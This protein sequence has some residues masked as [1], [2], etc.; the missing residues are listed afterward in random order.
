MS[1]P[2]KIY[3]SSF[4]LKKR[5]L[6][7]CTGFLSGAII[8][9]FMALSLQAQ[10][11]PTK[12]PNV[13]LI[14]S[15]D[16]N[17]YMSCYGHPEVKTPNM[18]RLAKHAIQF[19]HAYCQYPLCNPSRTSFMS[20]LRPA[21]TK[22]IINDAPPRTYLKDIVFI[23]E[24]FHQFGYFTARVGKIAHQTYSDAIHWD[25][26]EFSPESKFAQESRTLQKAMPKPLYDKFPM[27]AADD[28]DKDEQDGKTA[29]RIV[30]LLEENKD[31]QFFIAA[32][33]D[34]PHFPLVAP[35]K[36]FDLYPIDKIK[37]PYAPPDDI[38]DV[39]PIA[40]VNYLKM[41]EA[42]TRGYIQG[43][44]ACASFCDA[45][46]GILL[47]AMDRL[48]L[49][50]NT[51]VVFFG[52]H[53][54]CIGEHG[55][56]WS[57]DMLF[58]EATRVPYFVAAPGKKPAVCERLIEMVDLF[59]TL[60]DLCGI[61]TPSNL[62]G[63]SFG[64]LLDDPN[65]PWKKGAFTTVT[66]GKFTGLVPG[67]IQGTGNSVRTERYRFNEWHPLK[68]DKPDENIELYDHEKDPNEFN[69]VAHDPEYAKVLEEMKKLLHDDW[70][71][72]KP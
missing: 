38:K 22:I 70:Q 5:L 30:K 48:K 24:Y 16:W 51:I 10:T 57:K 9:I 15:D 2:K 29:L 54:F 37:I 3:V 61:P 4:G 44:L 13:L 23:P 12:K 65:R 32:G 69:N 36:Y 50:D 66:I 49:W 8:M 68:D 34:K 27:L 31:K 25:I 17:N 42:Q 11:A 47:D 63:T 1:F 52:D 40:L 7:R 14:I 56:C 21:T 53:G 60:T 67:R 58:E 19:D 71:K 41:P 20:G 6:T 43:Y 46:V 33:F 35:K 64:P 28:D 26:S 72:A 59:P 18:E 45:Q 62:E 39:P 55:G